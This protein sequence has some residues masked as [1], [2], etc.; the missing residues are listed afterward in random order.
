MQR[1]RKLLSGAVVAGLCCGDACCCSPS[2]R[3]E[4]VDLICCKRMPRLDLAPHCSRGEPFAETAQQ[5]LTQLP[6]SYPDWLFEKPEPQPP[7][8]LKDTPA[9]DVTTV[10]KL[11][12]MAREL[13]GVREF[14]VDL[15]HVDSCD[16]A[17]AAAAAFALNVCVGGNS[18][19][20]AD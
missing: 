18:D 3:C 11:E 9:I 2:S 19:G 6:G 20:Y 17:A 15:E 4:R 1:F 8:P 5:L 16:P 13:E 10:G 7:P 14:A 12:A